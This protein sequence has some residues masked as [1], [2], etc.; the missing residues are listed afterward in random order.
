MGKKDPVLD[1]CNSQQDR[2]IWHMCC[3][4]LCCVVCVSLVLDDDKVVFYP[5]RLASLVCTT[6]HKS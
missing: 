3:V 6:P 4:V 2:N 5:E 1:C